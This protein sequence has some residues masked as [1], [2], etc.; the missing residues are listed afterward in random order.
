[1]SSGAS[2]KLVPWDDRDFVAAF[3][4]AAARLAE[5]GLS[6]SSPSGAL[7][8]QRTLRA[9]GFPNATCYCERTPEDVLAARAPRCVVLRDGAAPMPLGGTVPA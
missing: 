9:S 7:I 6:L 5:D 3:E 4:A 8:L 1:M 2:V